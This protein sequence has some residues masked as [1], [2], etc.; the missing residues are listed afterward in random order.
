MR[1][2]W[3]MKDLMLCV[4]V[5]LSGNAGRVKLCEM[6]ESLINNGDYGIENFTWK[7]NKHLGHDDYFVIIV[8][9][10]HSVLLAKYS[11]KWSMIG[12]PLTQIWRMKDLMICVLFVFETLN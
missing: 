7:I 1:Q 4:L 12:A 3:G 8:Y 11:S 6:I 9:C 5:W 10:S 2:F